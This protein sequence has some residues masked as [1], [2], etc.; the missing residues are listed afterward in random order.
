MGWHQPLDRLSLCAGEGQ[1][2]RGLYELRIKRRARRLGKQQSEV[3][4]RIARTQQNLER[5][6]REAAKKWA[7]L[8]DVVIPLAL[9]RDWL[10]EDPPTWE[11]PIEGRPRAIVLSLRRP[12]ADT[13]HP[14]WGSDYV[15]AAEGW[16]WL[17]EQ[18]IAQRWHADPR[19]PRWRP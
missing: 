6:T 14:D 12:G 16:L 10:A 8:L 7:S 2:M 15:W 19:V 5:A 13:A 3:W 4:E 9:N 17:H 1:T 11:W 18:G